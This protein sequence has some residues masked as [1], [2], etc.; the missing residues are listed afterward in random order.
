MCTASLTLTSGLPEQAA[1]QTPPQFRR[2]AGPAE[3]AARQPLRSGPDAADS[4]PGSGRHP[5]RLSTHARP[6]QTTTASTPR[7]CTAVDSTQRT[8]SPR[9]QAPAHAPDARSAAG[10]VYL[11]IFTPANFPSR[12]CSFQAQGSGR[13]APCTLS[14]ARCTRCGCVCL[15]ACALG[16]CAPLSRRRSELGVRC[17]SRAGAQASP[18]RVR[19]A[20]SLRCPAHPCAEGCAAQL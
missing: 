19:P 6:L 7:P 10:A 8:S 1:L 20:H 14:D 11:S 4:P 13:R 18:D 15:G 5:A 12:L 3:C 9:P 16:T 2:S 17:S